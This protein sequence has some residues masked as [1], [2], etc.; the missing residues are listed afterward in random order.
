MFR[1]P[2][3]L[4]TVLATLYTTVFASPT[5]SAR[6]DQD[7]NRTRTLADAADQFPQLLPLVEGN[8]RFRQSI[9]ESD[10]PDLLWSLTANGQHPEFLF[11]GCR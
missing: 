9:A 10:K 4:Y 11:L 7:Q 5:V 2:F 6:S 3:L 1:K 8:A